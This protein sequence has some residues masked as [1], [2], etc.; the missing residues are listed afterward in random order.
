MNIE[1][2][3]AARVIYIVLSSPTTTALTKSGTQVSR[4][5]LRWTK[6]ETLNRSTSS[7]NSLLYSTCDNEATHS[8]LCTR[9][10]E[11]V[12]ELDWSDLELEG[13]GAAIWVIWLELEPPSGW[14]EWT[15][16]EALERPGAPIVIVNISDFCG[17]EASCQVFGNLRLAG[18]CGSPPCAEIRS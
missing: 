12:M 1:R 4:T 6:L 11:A 2:Y 17:V 18:K 5:V 10:A 13:A 7:S 15:G 9:L 3:S 16:A 8:L 14:L